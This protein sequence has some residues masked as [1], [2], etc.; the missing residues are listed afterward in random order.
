MRSHCRFAARYWIAVACLLVVSCSKDLSRN[1]AK[2]ELVSALGR[3]SEE[4]R[5]ERVY[6]KSYG[7]GGGSFPVA[8]LVSGQ[9]YADAKP[10][11]DDL[12]SRGLITVTER[13]A[14]GECNIVQMRVELT[15]LGKQFQSI[16]E[17]D[18]LTFKQCEIVV[19]EITGIRSQP[20]LGVS[21]VRYTLRRRN[22]T[23]AMLTD[24]TQVMSRSASFSRFDDGW[25]LADGTRVY[26]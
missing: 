24:T 13:P 14:F 26:H 5:V 2:A 16:N 15:D 1:R 25:R 10:K 12:T 3:F 6:V 17:P 23:P 8:C 19:D 7:G 21:E 9:T 18:Y 20:E 4:I 11:L 22:C